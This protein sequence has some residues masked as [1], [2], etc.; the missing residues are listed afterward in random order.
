[1]QIEEKVVIE[2]FEDED[3]N[4]P[5][6]D[7]LIKLPVK[8]SSRIIKKKEYLEKYTIPKLKNKKQFLEKIE[9][10]DTELWELKFPIS[11]PYRSVCIVRGNKIVML[12][13]FKGSGSNGRVLKYAVEVSC[14]RAID[15]DNRFQK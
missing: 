10:A 5:I 4:S 3:G 15:W 1:M 8:E 7:F 11:P 12:E 13:M 6:G 9:G 2:A 14:E